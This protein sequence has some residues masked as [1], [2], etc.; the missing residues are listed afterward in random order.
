[1]FVNLRPGAGR[2]FLFS[3]DFGSLPNLIPGYVNIPCI[4]TQKCFY[5]NL[6]VDAQN[7]QFS[8]CPTYLFPYKQCKVLFSFSRLSQ[9]WK[10]T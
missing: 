1:M 5:R 6:I 4:H 3:S 2:D 8:A 10:T 9:H 7:Q